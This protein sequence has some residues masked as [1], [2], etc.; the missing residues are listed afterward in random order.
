MVLNPSNLSVWGVQEGWEFKVISYIVSWCPGLCSVAV[1]RH[2]DYGNSYKRK[3]LKRL[4]G[5]L[6]T[7][8]EVWS[9]IILVGSMTAGM[10]LEKY[11]RATF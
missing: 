2:C 10:V 11:L 6:L 3:K 9:I 8:L 5:D 1:K 7:V 4:I